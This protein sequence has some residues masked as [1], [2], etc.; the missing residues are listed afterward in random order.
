MPSSLNAKG[1][2]EAVRGGSGLSMVFYGFV[3]GRPQLFPRFFRLSSQPQQSKLQW[4]G[5]ADH[6]AMACA[7]ASSVESWREAC[8]G[9]EDGVASL[10]RSALEATD[11]T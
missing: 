10:V 3:F 6:E 9:Q 4:V 7:P 8:L 5:V 1:W 11:V 2:V